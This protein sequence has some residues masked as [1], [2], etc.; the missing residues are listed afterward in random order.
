MLKYSR[1]AYG[2]DFGDIFAM[3]HFTASL[4]SYRSE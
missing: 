4:I 1:F 2:F 3:C